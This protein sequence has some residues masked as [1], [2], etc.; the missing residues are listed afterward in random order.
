MLW[1]T[2]LPASKYSLHA[3]ILRGDHGSICSWWCCEW[4]WWNYSVCCVVSFLTL[5]MVVV[6]LLCMLCYDLQW[7]CEFV[8]KWR[9][10]CV[11]C[12]VAFMMLWICGEI[13]KLLC[14]LCW[15]LLDAVNG[16]SEIIVYVLLKLS[17]RCE[18]LQ[19]NYC[20][21]CVEAF[22]T[23]WM[24]AVKLL[25]MLCWSFLDAVNGCSEITVYVVLRPS[26]RCEWLQWNYCVCCV[27]AFLTL[28]MVA[29]KLLFMLSCGLLD[30][31]NGCS[32]ITVYVV[33]WPSWRCEW[34]QW[35]YCLCCVVAFLTL[36]MGVV[37]LLC[38]LCCVL[39]MRYNENYR[40]G[41]TNTAE[42]KDV[43]ALLLSCE[44]RIKFTLLLVWNVLTSISC[45]CSP[46][47]I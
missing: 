37:K 8:V 26:W 42:Q 20:L 15:G 21:C 27:V 45:R 33:L 12:V 23:L 5:W 36:W 29:V 18:W 40:E 1:C 22:L 47:E 9:N 31:V 30:A 16:C 34:L 2:G 3:Y 19:W 13:A 28:W 43:V 4:L 25:C 6:K 35:N 46:L 44:Y 11:C 32:Q 7:R 24:V 39:C 17:W 14:M 10:Y 41:T 38:M